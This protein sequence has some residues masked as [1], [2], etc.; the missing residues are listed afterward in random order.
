MTTAKCRYC[1]RDYAV[2]A[3]H[4]RERLDGYC[5]H[6]CRIAV[7]AEP[8][9]RHGR[10]SIDS[11][12]FPEFEAG[13]Y[14]EPAADAEEAAPVVDSGEVSAALHG[15]IAPFLAMHWRTQAVVLARLANPS[16]PVRWIAARLHIR[17]QAAHRRMVQAAQ[18]WPALAGLVRY[19]E[20][21]TNK[22]RENRT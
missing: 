17:T 1:G 15:V 2:E 12:E 19:A 5:S 14:T 20:E 7:E 22:R 21:R 13:L 16:R 8:P 11:A 6:G 18:Q 10:C 4:R 9:Q 3:Y